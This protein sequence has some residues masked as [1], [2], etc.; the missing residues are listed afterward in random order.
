MFAYM[1]WLVLTTGSPASCPD[2]WKFN[3]IEKRLVVH[4]HKWIH[5]D[6]WESPKIN[7]VRNTLT[8]Q[9]SGA[10]TVTMILPGIPARAHRR[11]NIL[12]LALGIHG[13]QF[14]DL[15]DPSR[16]QLVL[17]R[18]F[19]VPIDGFVM[20][21][22]KVI[23][24]SGGQPVKETITRVSTCQGSSGTETTPRPHVRLLED[25]PGTPPEILLQPIVR[26][27]EV[28]V[29]AGHTELPL[30]TTGKTL[31]K[32]N[33]LFELSGL[34][35]PYAMTEGAFL[36][37][38]GMKIGLTDRLQLGYRNSLRLMGDKHSG[39]AP[40]Y[41]ALAGFQLKYQLYQGENASVALNYLFLCT[42]L[43]FSWHSYWGSF[44]L[45]TG[46]SA[47][48]IAKLVAD[49][50]PMEAMVR[51]GL[52]LRF[53]QHISLI[54]ELAQLLEPGSTD[55]GIVSLGFRYHRKNWYLDV[56][57]FLGLDSGDP[58]IA[59][60]MAGLGIQWN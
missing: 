34:A 39:N 38:F 57:G 44:T 56:S 10:F 49:K 58:F 45:G 11:Q 59:V 25:L 13:I 48:S 27:P 30:F 50:R 35:V 16:P 23:P 33:F 5:P 21:G 14:I 17:Q 36:D 29:V 60:M 28:T 52:Q 26:I 55:L 8:V 12:I 24:T 6:P 47:Y 40:E 7:I 20:E 18:T 3:T 1:L 46:T 22:D 37:F 53:S 4:I 9:G 41:I 32:G 15:Q 2:T 31:P 42:E 19:R 51:A 43:V 54:S